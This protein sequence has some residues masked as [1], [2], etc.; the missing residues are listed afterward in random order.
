MLLLT[1]AVFFFFNYALREQCYQ[2]HVH[3]TF[4]LETLPKSRV[5]TVLQDILTSSQT[6]FFQKKKLEYGNTGEAFGNT[7]VKKV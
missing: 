7:K 2:I 5:T 1:Q 4:H 3:T 6:L